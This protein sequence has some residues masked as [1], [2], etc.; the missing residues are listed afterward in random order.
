MCQHESVTWTTLSGRGTVY[1][2]TILHKSMGPWGEAAPFVVAYVE[3]DE[4]P[5]VLTNVSPT[6]RP[7]STSAPPVEAVF[8][9]VDEPVDGSPATHLLRFVAYWLKRGS[10]FSTWAARPSSASPMPK[11]RNS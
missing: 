3:L 5:R 1:A 11:P 6:I 2:R 7:P 10:R 9:P 4:G 8:V